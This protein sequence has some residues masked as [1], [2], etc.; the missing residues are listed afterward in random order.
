MEQCLR[1]G[2]SFPDKISKAPDLLPG[3]ELFYLSF[4]TL[5]DSRQL[6]TGL[7]P[8]PWKV[9]HDYCVAYEIVGEQKE[10]MHHHIKQL[11]SAYL[12]HANRK[13]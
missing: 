1:E 3:L 12:E 11:D 10:E 7:G 8:I 9:V 2:L 4:M 6:G 5:S 13:K